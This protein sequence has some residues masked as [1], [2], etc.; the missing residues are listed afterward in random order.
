MTAE[1]N[2][3]LFRGKWGKRR[4]MRTGKF[5][6]KFEST[7][8]KFLDDAGINYKYEEEKIKYYKPVTNHVYTPDFRLTKRKWYIEV[9]GLFTAEDRKKHLY[10]KDQGGPEIRFL[11]YNANAKISKASKTTYAA[12]CDKNGFEWAHKKIPQEWLDE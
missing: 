3:N 4:Q 7:T 9:K 8:A 5:R 11:F 2:K 12:W 6:S 10:I 1:N